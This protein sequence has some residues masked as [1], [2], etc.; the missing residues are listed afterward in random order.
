MPAAAQPNPDFATE[1][2]RAC[3]EPRGHCLMKPD[4]TPPKNSK[5]LAKS[6]QSHARTEP[7][8]KI[9]Q[10]EFDFSAQSARPAFPVASACP[11]ASTKR[12]SR[13]RRIARHA[14]HQPNRLAISPE[15]FESEP[16]GL[17]SDSGRREG[18]LE[19]IAALLTTVVF[20]LGWA[21]MESE[22]VDF[23][24]SRYDAVGPVSTDLW[25]AT[26]ADPNYTPIARSRLRS[27]ILWTNI[28][29]SAAQADE[30]S[31]PWTRMTTREHGQSTPS[32]PHN[33][34]PLRGVTTPRPA[35]ISSDPN[36]SPGAR[37]FTR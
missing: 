18:A 31:D 28:P 3:H 1:C 33:T 24:G 25:G 6:L 26:T 4:P 22:Q 14:A 27:N 5:E 19:A 36:S 30:R 11:A 29:E 32:A 35:P 13:P 10:T 20:G 7:P 37:N 15:A 8:M 2:D 17:P 23:P 12:V 9:R 16:Q 34:L 21:A